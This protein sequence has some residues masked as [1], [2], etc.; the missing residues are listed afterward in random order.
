MK[1]EL[2]SWTHNPIKTIAYAASRCYDS[3]PNI[4][5]VKHCISSGHLSVL[6]H[7]NFTF[8]ISG[9][10]RN[11]SHQLVRH[12]TA[13]Y[14]QRSQRYTSEDNF[15]YLVPSKCSG[16][17]TYEYANAMLSIQDTYN[18]L[19]E[20]GWA[21]EDARNVLP[22]A[23]HTELVMTIDLRN[24]AH[25]MNERLCT[26]AQEE[27]RQLAIRMQKA[28]L[29]S[30]DKIGL[31]DE[32]IDIIMRL[33]V[34]KCGAGK[35]KYCPEAKSCGRQ[36]TAK[37]TN[38][39]LDNPRGKGQW[40]YTGGGY[41]YCSVCGTLYEPPFGSLNYCSCCGAEMSEEVTDA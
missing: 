10:S 38:E 29:D 11:C 31:D 15:S 26:R 2:I 13:S 8:H 23:C 17:D 41:R 35:I 40:L 4:K 6:E 28:I 14:S 33:C 36:K 34:P 30:R 39:I 12:R 5:V 24:L 37:E 19:R 21:A 7:A 9:I 27:I 3:E 18:E 1:V 16:N 32:E 25:F 20:R 22:G